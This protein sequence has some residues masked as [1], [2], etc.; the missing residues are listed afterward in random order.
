MTCPALTWWQ[1]WDL[2]TCLWSRNV[3]GAVTGPPDAGVNVEAHSQERRIRNLWQSLQ[4]A[5]A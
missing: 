5:P 3:R 1:S 2:N 4:A